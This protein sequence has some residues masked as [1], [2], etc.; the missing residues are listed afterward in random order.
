MVYNLNTSINNINS[1]KNPYD[2]AL[3]DSDFHTDSVA[4]D[5]VSSLTG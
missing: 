5:E 3:H 1:S 2:M 4:G